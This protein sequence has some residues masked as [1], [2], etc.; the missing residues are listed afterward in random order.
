M[1]YYSFSLEFLLWL[2]IVLTYCG[3]SLL[4]CAMPVTC[5]F[6]NIT[7]VILSVF[8]VPTIMLAFQ[9]K[10]HIQRVLSVFIYT[11]ICQHASAYILSPQCDMVN[12]MQH[13]MHIQNRWCPSRCCIAN[14]THRIYITVLI[15]YVHHN[16]LH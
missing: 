16:Q 14:H 7:S 1:S 9:Y 2:K 12:N 8:L 10:L 13:I 3:L 11:H 15:I 4:L 5:F 6:K